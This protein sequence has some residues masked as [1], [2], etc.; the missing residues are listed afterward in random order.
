MRGESCHGV[1]RAEQDRPTFRVSRKTSFRSRFSREGTL[2]WQ[3]PDQEPLLTVPGLS[4][5]AVLGCHAVTP[6]TS[7][8]DWA[9]L[10]LCIGDAPGEAPV[11]QCLAQG[12]GRPVHPFGPVT[13]SRVLELGAASSGPGQQPTHTTPY[14]R[15]VLGLFYLPY[16]LRSF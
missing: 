2:G 7:G 8:S 5:E 4:D 9:V 14:T 10:R 13:L 6:H 11:S 15:A 3:T 1:P 16:K 12:L